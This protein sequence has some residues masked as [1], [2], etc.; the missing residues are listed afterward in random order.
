M[1]SRPLRGLL[2]R[3]LAGAL[4]L[5]LAAPASARELSL[6][7]LDQMGRWLDC[8]EGVGDEAGCAEPDVD[9]AYAAWQSYHHCVAECGRRALCRKAAQVP[10]VVGS[11]NDADQDGCADGD[12]TQPQGPPQLWEKDAVAS[13]SRK[14]LELAWLEKD[15]KGEAFCYLDAEETIVALASLCPDRPGNTQCQDTTCSV[16]Q[17]A[18]DLLDIA[19]EGAGQDTACWY[20]DGGT[21]T[22]PLYCTDFVCDEKPKAANAT[23]CAD[24][25]DDS[26]ATWLEEALNLSGGGA[27]C[28]AD[29]A[30]G[31]DQECA[32]FVGATPTQQVH[33]GAG[34]CVARACDL[35]PA[36]ECTA[37]SLEL[38][39]EDDQVA[40]V[41]VRYDYSPIPARMLD[42]HVVFD[43]T[44]SLLDARPL[45]ALTEFGKDFKY[46]FKSDGTLRLMVHELDGTSAIPF[47]PIVE[48]LFQ[49]S[50]DTPADGG[51][52]WGVGFSTDKSLLHKAIAPAQ[53]ADDALI[54][55]DGGKLVRWGAAVQA[56]HP[57]DPTL[58][59]LQLYYPFD[60]AD[61]GAAFSEVPSAEALCERV[62]QCA[63]ELDVRI[64]AMHMARLE[65]LQEGMVRTSA[66]V[67]G[68]LQQA[69]WMDGQLDHLE[70]PVFYNDAPLTADGQSLTGSMWFYAEDA[71]KTSD[72]LPADLK[73]PRV[74]FAHDHFG[75]RSRFALAWRHAAGGAI[76]LM[77]V[78]GDLAATNLVKATLLIPPAGHAPL[79]ALEWHHV[80]FVLDAAAGT[81]DV[82]VDGARWQTGMALTGGSAVQ[83]PQFSGADVNLHV[84]G[85]GVYGSEP[86]ERIYTSLRQSGRWSIHRT[87]PGGFRLDPLIGDG[88]HSFVD[89]DYSPTLDRLLYASD[90]TG[91]MEI[92]VAHGDGS[93]RRQVTAG[94][95]D[96]FLG[97]AARRPRWSPTGEALVFESNTFDLQAQDNAGDRVSHLYYLAWDVDADVPVGLGTAGAGAF[98]PLDYGVL[99]DTDEVGTHR[100]TKGDDDHQHRMAFW[101][102]GAANQGGSVGLGRLLYERSDP[103]WQQRAVQEL[104]IGA[105]VQLTSQ[106]KL[107]PDSS[108]DPST[109]AELLAARRVFKTVVGA[110]SASVEPADL[111]LYRHAT[112]SWETDSRFILE[113]YDPQAATE[114]LTLRFLPSTMANPFDETPDCWDLDG[115]SALDLD[116]DIDQ[117]G[118][119][120]TADC[121]PVRVLDLYV[122]YDGEHWED[123]V[124]KHPLTHHFVTVEPVE[125]GQ[126]RVQVLP[127][128]TVSSTSIAALNG[129]LAPPAE[130][131]DVSR[132]AAGPD[133]ALATTGGKRTVVAWGDG[134]AAK[135]LAPPEALQH[136]K[137]LAAGDRFALALTDEGT[138]VQWGGGL[139]P[140]GDCPDATLALSP[141]APDCGL[142]ASAD[143]PAC[144]CLNPGLPE[145]AKPDD[146]KAILDAH[147]DDEVV[148]IAA[149]RAHA[150][151]LQADGRPVV[152]GCN[153]NGQAIVPDAL[154]PPATVRAIAAT[155]DA[156]Y[157]LRDDGLIVGWGVNAVQLQTP[158]LHTAALAAGPGRLAVLGHDH[159]L[160]VVPP[161]PSEQAPPP[162][163]V[164]VHD[165]VA[166]DGF[167]VVRR[168]DGTLR[169]L[170][171]AP[172]GLDTDS[173]T[174][175]SDLSAW[176]APAGAVLAVRAC[177]HIDHDG[178]GV[179]TTEAAT[180]VPG[181]HTPRP[182][183]A[184]SAIA[185]LL[186]TKKDGAVDAS[187]DPLP[188]RRIPSG[189]LFVRDLT[190][191]TTSP[192]DSDGRFELAHEAALSPSGRRVAVAAFTDGRPILLRTA[193][194]GDATAPV[195]TAKGA[196]PLLNQ[197]VHTRGL[198]WVSEERYFPCNFV[199]AQ[200]N[201]ATKGLFLA[202][203][204][205][206]HHGGLDDLQLYLG[207]RPEA[208]LLSDAS[209]GLAAMGEQMPVSKAPSC[210]SS[211]AECP[212]YHLCQDGACKV[213]T[214]QDALG[215][216]D[217][218][219]CEG[220]GSR[221][222][223]RP[224]TVDGT[225]TQDWVCNADCNTDGQCFTQAC[226][227]GPCRFCDDTTLTCL[228]CRESSKTIGGLT[229]Q[230]T[231]GCPDERSWRCESGTCVTDCYAQVDGTSVYVCDPLFE[232][233][234][235]G[236]CVLHDWGWTD[237]SPMS[238]FGLGDM[239]RAGE[240][241]F[242]AL[243]QAVPVAIEAF[244]VADYAHVPELEVQVKG[245][246]Y[247]AAAWTSVAHLL[248]HARRHTAAVEQAQPG[249]TMRFTVPRRFEQMRLL[250][251]ASAIDD[252]GTGQSVYHDKAYTDACLQALTLPAAQ[253][254]ISAAALCAQGSQPHLGYAVGLPDHAIECPAAQAGCPTA[255]TNK[256][257][258]QLVYLPG[259]YPAVLV[260][261]VEVDGQ[262]IQMSG[263]AVTNRIC[264][265]GPAG[266]ATAPSSAEDLP[267]F[268]QVASFNNQVQGFALL[269]CA[270]GH[271]DLAD[272][273]RPSVEL[274]VVGLTP[275]QPPKAGVEVDNGDFCLYQG[276]GAGLGVKQA[277]YA[278]QSDPTLDPGTAFVSTGASIDFESLQMGLFRTFGYD[279][280][281]QPAALPTHCATVSGW[282][283]SLD[284]GLTLGL[285]VGVGDVQTFATT[286]GGATS[287]QFTKPGAGGGPGCTVPEGFNLAVTIEGQP[288]S[289][290]RF[291]TLV[292]SGDDI[293]APGKR[294]MG[295]S[296]VTV[297][298]TCA[299]LGTASV[300]VTGMLGGTSLGVRG[301]LGGDAGPLVT[302]TPSSNGAEVPLGLQGQAGSPL[303]V[304]VFEP[305]FPPGSQPNMAC[306]V[307]SG[308]PTQLGAPKTVVPI[309]CVQ[310]PYSTLSVRITAFEEDGVTSVIPKRSLV[311]LRVRD[312]A[313]EEALPLPSADWTA[314]TQTASFTSPRPQGKAFQ[315]AV[316]QQP[317]GR[318]YLCTPAANA[319]GVMPGAAHTVDIVCVRR[320]T[321]AIS[322]E[323]TGLKSSSTLTLTWLMTP[324]QQATWAQ[325]LQGAD[326]ALWSAEQL[327]Q[328]HLTWQLQV[329]KAA[330]L[331][332]T[333]AMPFVF[334]VGST[335][336]TGHGTQSAPFGGLPYGAIFHVGASDPE[337]PAQT[338]SALFAPQVQDPS[339]LGAVGSAS[340]PAQSG[341]QVTCQAKVAD[342]QDL[343]A[344]GGTLGGLGVSNGLRLGLRAG[345]TQTPSPGQTLDVAANATSFS[346]Q[347]PIAD[348]EPYRVTV[349]RQPS[350]PAKVCTFDAKGTAP[351][352][353]TS[354]EGT[355]NGADVADVAL[356]CAPGSTLQVEVV[357]PSAAGAWFRVV[358]VRD[359][360]GSSDVA[361]AGSVLVGSRVAKLDGG[362]KGKAVLWGA[363]ALGT[364]ATVA[365]GTYGFYLFVDKNGEPEDPQGN[366]WYGAQDLAAYQKITI[367]SAPNE[368]TVVVFNAEQTAGALPAASLGLLGV[369]GTTHTSYTCYWLSYH[370]VPPVAGL[371]VT[372]TADMP[373]VAEQLCTTA[374]CVCPPGAGQSCYRPALPGGKGN[375]TVYCVAG[376]AASSLATA[377][378]HTATVTFQN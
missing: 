17:C 369:N 31:F 300:Q 368:H 108:A 118:L 16:V 377:T 117:D 64:K 27:L 111:A 132:V 81:V 297:A 224:L 169:V 26:L 260:T 6:T 186:F 310:V 23:D 86:A 357:A 265:Y 119:G 120:T 365:P 176:G 40:L 247:D 350:N 245:G 195:W 138:V 9:A 113:T 140:F 315:I 87:D 291:C 145:D 103:Q 232:Y 43:D 7:E 238:F 219:K 146:C 42:L 216:P 273:A 66:V 268:G 346:F 157:A 135:A 244:G 170:G 235:G 272:G 228:E 168:F 308:A 261:Q 79:R 41:H 18:A 290:T 334:T 77:W 358:A 171:A 175:V 191:E 213:V 10:G 325:G 312:L 123:S 214:C 251:S 75:E 83:C 91:S 69:A 47:G 55:T 65:R 184:N 45:A 161:F 262:L 197:P 212:P 277:C 266:A 226:A 67:D 336:A 128:P 257:A 359:Y 280:D 241:W 73:T 11:P 163:L 198:S 306:A 13:I 106:L 225:L 288:T 88:Q 304:A 95:G 209:R 19:C 370:Y 318:P 3:A 46:V 174:A 302:L 301:T 348:L 217:E 208:L 5:A 38:V 204:Y 338:C 248:V 57:D 181:L 236:H 129:V 375:Y 342:G 355:V 264:G 70:L 183:P 14:D 283:A 249:G 53:D 155:G 165:V 311:P 30:C 234:S 1:T 24:P 2:G 229:F 134:A 335:Y 178:D 366:P 303:G 112:V 332:A 136:V 92:W 270:Y 139:T 85:D 327:A 52:G 322:G 313:S 193:A 271:N 180:C 284:A 98:E 328:G 188:Q 353:T 72:S 28:S 162:W 15:G 60:I 125:E 152:W 25:D 341:V 254:G 102:E 114:P 48:L 289:G 316:D 246:Q 344:V 292:A 93:G 207:K 356:T 150:I 202:K 253:H 192:L 345:D 58:A 323:V 51:A 59:R 33:I 80:A 89:P 153:D 68:V 137:A 122:Q 199:A 211:H 371:P 218:P 239:R 158:A 278:W 71:T 349:E 32:S 76:E 201:H 144:Q 237:L 200:L 294:I 154:T 127:K 282:D 142:Q 231:E 54:E 116:E 354:A 62:A 96:A 110:G 194:A 196:V 156:S 351:N 307:A 330:G 242:M 340:P 159:Q 133:Y 373:I 164:G 100:L 149:G 250:L 275:P 99:V 222:V 295:T 126:L 279:W 78:D 167:M 189:G 317:D 331:P 74:L 252:G 299:A 82:Y 187:P 143:L 287:H 21:P 255:Y 84:E 269:N 141:F 281:Y 293:G 309:T 258:Q 243:S 286:A 227:N 29:A 221:C 35:N 182:M 131:F 285:R 337:T 240:P 115:D 233:C 173:P 305:S 206:P 4:L 364:V 36:A 147:F 160:T 34:Q 326:Q 363:G 320:P 50:Q 107:I 12:T 124:V 263:P 220:L 61:E 104:K 267:K 121:H 321:A 210:V 20:P 179:D 378:D 185:D 314:S 319:V 109:E 203:R 329:T 333:Q 343:F 44:L 8:M 362:G 352:A 177:Y 37:F 63:N 274:P 101:L 151:A 49:K 166:G 190:A 361:G 298:V 205:R 372:A 97:I 215:G 223:M 259:G 172:A 230:V 339:T 296:D 324:G 22:R 130:T 105:V 148:A 360:A 347:N 256:D 94:F 276:S 56:R 90:E 367:P 39:A 374:N 376:G